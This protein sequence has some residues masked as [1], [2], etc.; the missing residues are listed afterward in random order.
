MEQW[1]VNLQHMVGQTRSLEFAYVGSR[2][3]D[4]ISARD[5]NQP[6]ASPIVPNLRPNP[7]FADITLIESRASSLFNALQVRYQERPSN[8]ALM[9]LSYYAGQIDRRCLGVLY[10]RWRS[11]FSAEQPG[12]RG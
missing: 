9:L 1:N 10:Q 3:H 12:S 6:P 11:E 5:M 4:L 8:G 2:G 7:L